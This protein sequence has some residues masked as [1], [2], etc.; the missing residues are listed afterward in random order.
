MKAFRIVFLT[1]CLAIG[2]AA[3]TV[4]AADNAANNSTEAK[5]GSVYVLSVNGAIGPALYN[6]MQK[7][8]EA[9]EANNAQLI[10]VELNT[11]G[12]LLSTTREMATLIINSRIP[13]AVHVTP[14]G[15]HA[16]SAGTFIVYAS[17]VA[18]MADGTNIGA[19]TPIQMGN[20]GGSSPTPQ[21]TSKDDPATTNKDALDLKALADT[22]AFIRGLA[23]MRGRNIEWSQKAVTNGDSLTAQE[24]VDKNVVELIANSREDL[25]AKL[26]NRIIRVNT[27]TNKTLKLKVAP[28]IEYKQDFKTKLLTVL[29]DPNIAMI[30]I[31]IGI[32]G[33][34]LELYNPG[35]MV[36]GVVGGISLLMGFYAMNILPINMT[37]LLLVLLGFGMLIAEIFI[38]SFGIL[39]IGGILAFVL[40]SSMMFEGD[41]M[42]GLALDMG[43]VY[44]IAACA[45]LAMIGASMLMARSMKMQPTTGPEGM[46][47]AAG[48]I[49]EW[50]NGQGY[51]QVHGELWQATSSLNHAFGKGD[52]VTISGFDDLL[53]R[54]RPAN[55]KI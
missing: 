41:S 49:V 31:S 55:E 48:H 54:V 8:F 22:N 52:K 45:F 44:G 35:S 53:L 28:V 7:G 43:L 19:A 30:L 10:V 12:G 50:A 14:A 1:I 18:A 6:Y 46:L 26:E 16:A 15:G 47:G 23:K 21:D 11:P 13:V 20:P 33:L 29:T 36:G 34:T 42:P 39:G 27:G 3:Y 25:L 9:A 40:G 51:V 2:V 4:D 38:P 37:G 5:S 24:A 17:H 32:T